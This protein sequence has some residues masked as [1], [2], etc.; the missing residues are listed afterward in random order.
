ARAEKRK[1]KTARR[2]ER[3]QQDSVRPDAPS[4]VDPDIAHIQPG[5]QPPADWQVEVDDGADEETEDEA[6]SN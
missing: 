5:P 1:E 6:V 2:L 3:A 4:G